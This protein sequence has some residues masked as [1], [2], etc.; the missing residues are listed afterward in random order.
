MIAPP[1]LQ[2]EASPAPSSLSDGG[3][4][5][6]H[7]DNYGLTYRRLSISSVVSLGSRWRFSGERALRREST[8]RRALVSPD[9]APTE[10]GSDGDDDD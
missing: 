8:P 7:D 3:I 4:H 10:Q 1:A 5:C 9:Y 2:P 6:F